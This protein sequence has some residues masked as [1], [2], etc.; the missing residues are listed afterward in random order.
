M[1]QRTCL[2]GG[3]RGYLRLLAILFLKSRHGE[4]MKLR[5]CW[6]PC[7]DLLTQLS[8]RSTPI[9]FIDGNG[10]V[11]KY[12]IDGEYVDPPD[13]DAVGPYGDY[14][15]SV[16]GGLI[17]ELRNRHHL[18]LVNTH[19]PAGC[20]DTFHNND[21]GSSRIYRLHHHSQSFTCQC[22]PCLGMVSDRV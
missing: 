11:G 9:I 13:G 17:R 4:H 21:N 22:T 20:G 19:C 10:H 8:G 7:E 1:V 16:Q 5:L 3:G 15:Q 18:A 6:S 2:W 14:F 12:K